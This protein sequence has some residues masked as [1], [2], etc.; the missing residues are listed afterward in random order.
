[1]SEALARRYRPRVFEDLIGQE[2]VSQTLS[3]ALS[4]DRLSHA[5]LF[6]GLRG[7]GK[8]STAR[9][10]AKALLCENG[11]SAHPCGECEHCRAADG[12]KHID[13]I[14]MDAASNRKIDDIRELIEHT[15]YKPSMGR[16]KIFIID[17]VH[18]LTNE[19]FNAL[20]KTLEEPPSF[21]KFILATTDPLKVPATILSRSQ[22]FRFKKISASLVLAHL[23]H[24]CNQEGVAFEKSALQMLARSGG[25]SLR[26]TLTLLDQAIVY[27]QGSV[28]DAVV[29]K[30]LGIIDPKAIEGL[31]G[32]VMQRDKEGVKN[33]IARY[34]EYEAGMILDQ[35]SIYLHEKLFE[36]DKMLT[37]MIIER[38]FRVISEG[39]QLLHLGSDEEFVLS[40]SL[41]KMIE[42][43]SIKDIDEMIAELE[44]SITTGQNSRPA[45]STPQNDTPEEKSEPAPK[46]AAH[47]FEKLKQSIYDRDYELGR[48]FEE[49]IEYV[50]HDE[51]EIRW[52]SNAQGRC[53]NELA[54]SYS[55]IK[56]FIKEIFGPVKV[57]KVNKDQNGDKVDKET[58]DSDDSGQGGSSCM[59]K[60]SGLQ[61]TEAS[62][63]LDPK[64]IVKAPMVAKAAQLF[65]PEKIKIQPKV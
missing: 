4:Q 14:E 13:I 33:F 61:E 39:K 8:T 11:I 52:V 43:V 32:T 53:Q 58:Q 15:K 65:K 51:D 10:F 46:A 18:M 54:Q 56:G 12:A 36:D 23:E 45:V 41:F 7:S 59:E 1:M 29:T 24:I 37:P 28:D 42:A 3:Q 62:R 60:N 47:P 38:F 34:S 2:S 6:S 22:H 21:V 50:S 16:F 17:E 44:S 57:V 5:Y 49:S 48:C 9:I 27:A 55:I 35:L 63:E 64:Q 31:V 19:A 26:D 20:L 25:G 40:L 30:M